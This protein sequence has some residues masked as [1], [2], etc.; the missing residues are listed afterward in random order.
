MELEETM[1][2]EGT[3]E[4]ITS[5]AQFKHGKWWVYVKVKTVDGKVFDTF[6]CESTKLEVLK[7][8]NIGNKITFLN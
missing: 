3:I 8:S 7:S 1:G 5:S 6:V 2:I 4:K